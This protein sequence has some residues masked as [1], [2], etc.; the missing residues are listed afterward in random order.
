M[1]SRHLRYALFATI[2]VAGIATGFWVATLF[3]PAPELAPATPPSDF[4][5]PDIDGYSH[6]LSEWRGKVVLLNFWASWCAPCRDEIPL[7]KN[8]QTRYAAQGLQIVGIAIDDEEAVTEFQ[9]KIHFNYPILI[10]EIE[11]LD[12]LA[13][14]GNPSGSLPFSVVLDHAGQVVSRKLGSYRAPELETAIKAALAR[15]QTP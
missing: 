8:M 9:E 11:A 3:K 5:L 12:L 15:K 2:A 10:G 14:Y 4:A 7:L 1:S 13:P 6:H